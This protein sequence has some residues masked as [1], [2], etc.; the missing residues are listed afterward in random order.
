MAGDLQICNGKGLSAARKGSAQRALKPVLFCRH[1]LES[2]VAGS[3]FLP[4]Q[5][6]LKQAAS[7]LLCQPS[8][9]ESAPMTKAPRMNWRRGMWAKSPAMPGSGNPFVAAQAATPKGAVID[10]ISF[11]IAPWDVE[12]GCGARLSHARAEGARDRT[13]R[14]AHVGPDG[15]ITQDDIYQA[16]FQS[17]H[18]D[19]PPNG[20]NLQISWNTLD[21]RL[22]R[23]PTRL[24]PRR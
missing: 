21:K 1:R 13:H 6:L 5:Q 3:F 20:F 24:S 14:A 4:R 17:Y 18:T 15:K 2:R 9:L 11:G 10:H 22:W 7:F 19:T 12:A 23:W 16:A 8:G